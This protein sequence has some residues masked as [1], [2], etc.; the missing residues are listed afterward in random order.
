MCVSTTIQTH[1]A[2]S[3]QCLRQPPSRPW[4]S[5]QPL[6]YPPQ[7]AVL[8]QTPFT[9]NRAHPDIAFPHAHSTRPTPAALPPPRSESTLKCRRTFRR[10]SRTRSTTTGP[11]GSSIPHEHT[12]LALTR[13][14]CQVQAS[15]QV[16][17]YCC[18]YISSGA[19]CS[20]S[21]GLGM[22]QGIMQLIRL[23]LSSF[24]K[25]GMGALWV[26]ASSLLPESSSE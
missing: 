1:P 9:R 7:L 2:S 22:D 15:S 3:R 23:E 18:C 4:T 6:S 11:T 10:A 8:P 26:D 13:T 5:L 24:R 21:Q 20:C 19:V 17:V 12:C 25:L 14:F 16:V